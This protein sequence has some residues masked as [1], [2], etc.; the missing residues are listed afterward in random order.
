MVFKVISV[1]GSISPFPAHNDMYNKENSNDM[2]TCVLKFIALMLIYYII[3]YCRVPIA[4]AVVNFIGAI[5]LTH[6][7]IYMHLYEW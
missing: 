4:I 1:N 3:L 6:T 5:I 2:H 7:H